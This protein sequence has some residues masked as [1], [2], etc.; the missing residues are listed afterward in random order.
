MKW[1]FGCGNGERR[2][3]FHKA[4]NTK[5]AACNAAVFFSKRPNWIGLKTAQ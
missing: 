4:R 5:Q 2:F 1:L 3:G